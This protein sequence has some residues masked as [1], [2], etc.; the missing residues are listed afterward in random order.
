MLRGKT[1]KTKAATHII[2]VNLG[3]YTQIIVPECLNVLRHITAFIFTHLRIADCKLN[4]ERFI[5]T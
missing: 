2:K 1:Y 3:Q 5:E 4:G